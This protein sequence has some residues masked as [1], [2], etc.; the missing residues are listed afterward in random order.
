MI[1]FLLA[2]LK[3]TIHALIP[4]IYGYILAFFIANSR[5]LFS[6]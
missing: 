3:D 2:S 4:E 1:L 6:C 5:K